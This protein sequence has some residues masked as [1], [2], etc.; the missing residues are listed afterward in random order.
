MKNLK[1]HSLL[2]VGGDDNLKSLFQN[3]FNEIKS[4]DKSEILSFY[5]KER[6]PIIFFVDDIEPIREIRKFDRDIII[7]LLLTKIVSD[8]LLEA[9]KLRVFDLLK[10]PLNIDKLDK[11]LKLID[12]EL[13]GLY[14][15]NICWINGGYFFDFNIN[16]LYDSNYNE[17]KLTKKELKLLKILLKSKGKFVSS[18]VIEYNIWEE[19]SEV[20]DCR[21]RLKTLLNGLRRKLPPKTILNSY[22]LGYKIV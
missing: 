22:G 4:I 1:Y 9:I 17:I 6:Y 12:K 13:N 16:I 8:I 19:E 18:D 20:L 2:L 15:K 11:T 3:Y 10:F 14:K 7:V 5:D 21:G